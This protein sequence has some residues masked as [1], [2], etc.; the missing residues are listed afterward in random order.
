MTVNTFVGSASAEEIV[1]A[2][3]DRRVDVLAVEELTPMMLTR[4]NVAGLFRILPFSQR[5]AAR[6][7][8]DRDLD[9]LPDHRGHPAARHG[10]PGPPGAPRRRRSALWVIAAHPRSPTP[11]LVQGWA[12]EQR[13]LGKELAGDDDGSPRIVMGDFNAGGAHAVFRHLRARAGL[14]DAAD[15]AGLSSWPRMTWP[16]DHPVLPPLTR[17]DHVLVSSAFTA[18]SVDTVAVTGTD[19][20]AVVATLTAAPTAPCVPRRRSSAAPGIVAGG[21]LLPP[22]SGRPRTVWRALPHHA[23]DPFWLP[24]LA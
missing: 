8:R 17:I 7:Q 4:L 18:H 24:R 20:K 9:A 3:R 10:V 5:T 14:D 21:S 16:A 19:H 1:A 23:G 12:T 15:L 6:G 22:G 13:R 11:A 2:V